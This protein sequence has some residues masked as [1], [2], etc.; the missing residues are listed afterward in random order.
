MRKFLLSVLAVAVMAGTASAAQVSLQ[1]ASGLEI[2]ELDVSDTALIDVYVNLVGGDSMSGLF[3]GN[4]VVSPFSWAEV[5]DVIEMTGVIGAPGVAV[6]DSVLGTFCDPGDGQFAIFDYGVNPVIGPGNIFVGQLEIHVHQ[7]PILQE[8]DMIGIVFKHDTVFL[9]DEM[10]TAMTYHGTYG[11]YSGY[12]NYG[13]GSPY[14]PAQKKSPGQPMDPLWL[15]I[16][17]E[18][19]S[20]ALLALGGLAIARRRR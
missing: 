8:S 19:A 17:P 18:P 4:G 10:G 7:N 15:H 5:G 16:V 12:Y 2:E 1:W 13:K 14:V 9:L 6:G 11:I 3:F 20:L